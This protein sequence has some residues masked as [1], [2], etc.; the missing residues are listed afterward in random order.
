MW[1]GGAVVAVSAVAGLF[2]P[3][4]VVGQVQAEAAEPRLPQLGSADEAG[5]AG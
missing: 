2:I 1:I 3:R 4:R 5:A